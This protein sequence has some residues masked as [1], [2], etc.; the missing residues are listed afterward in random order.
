MLSRSSTLLAFVVPLFAAAALSAQC[1]TTVVTGV[2]NTTWTLAGS[3]YCVNATIAVNQL[4][5]QAGV[6]VR[7]A[8]GVTLQVGS[9]LRALGTRTQPVVFRAQNLASGRWGGIEF[10][11]PVPPSSSSLLENCL[12]TE[13]G[14]S[15]VRILDNDQVTLRGCAIRGN[16]SALDGGGL[17]VVLTSGSVACF[18][19]DIEG[20]RATRHG[21]GVATSTVGSAFVALVGCR[22]QNNIANPNNSAGT[23]LGAGIRSSG[24]LSLDGC[25]IAGNTLATATCGGGIAARGGGLYADNGDVTVDN[26]VILGNTCSAS[27]V[28][29]TCGGQSGLAEG[30]GIFADASVGNISLRNTLLCCN[31]TL[32]SGPSTTNRGSGIQT[33]SVNTSIENCTIARNS[34]EGCRV[35]AGTAT[36]T[37]CIVFANTGASI[38]GTATANYSCIQGGFA[39][40]TGNFAFNPQF[41]GTG[42]DAENFAIGQ[43]SPCIDAGDPSPTFNDG[44]RPP[45]QGSVRNDVG[46]LGGSS[47]CGFTGPSVVICGAQIYGTA[48]QIPEAMTIDWAFSSSQAPHP[49][50]LTITNGLPSSPALLLLGVQAVDTPLSGITL[51]VNPASA[52]LL[53]ITLTPA[54]DFTVPLDLQLPFLV[55]FPLFLQAIALPTAGSLRASNGLRVAACY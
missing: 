46:A 22:V 7:M 35:S 32:A 42:C 52:S 29:S 43:F 2:S 54:G 27:T 34:N 19:C 1:G 53:P 5:I 10:Q 41:V 40:G 51:L 45:G 12:I 25:M 30:A 4:T 6:E 3:P 36:L 26:C 23:Y 24:N 17:R 37:N 20:N 11:G 48:R 8:P 47:N 49:G 31:T 44:C 28:P 21:G 50:N 15:G 16:T 18:D 39:G 55:G 13:A 33:S 14:N 9:W 38:V